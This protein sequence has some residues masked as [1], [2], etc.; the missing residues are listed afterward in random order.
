MINN[1]DIIYYMHTEVQSKVLTEC[2]SYI[3]RMFQ[4][5]HA[6]TRCEWENT[7][8]T[9]LRS[10]MEIPNENRRPHRMG[11]PIPMRNMKTHVSLYST[12][13]PVRLWIHKAKNSQSQTRE[14]FTV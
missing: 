8:L 4:K 9:F 7:K 2:S 13:V 3:I 1:T 5:A 12:E 11:I 10:Y 14:Y 6:N